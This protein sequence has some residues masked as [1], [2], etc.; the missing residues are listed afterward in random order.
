MGI[1]RTLRR[2]LPAGMV[3]PTKVKFFGCVVGIMVPVGSDARIG[4]AF[5]GFMGMLMS[6]AQV[7]N[8]SDVLQGQEIVR[9]MMDSGDW[10]G[11]LN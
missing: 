5:E 11:V 9:G 8:M 6:R 10:S 1:Q 7:V 4:Q 2:N 3:V